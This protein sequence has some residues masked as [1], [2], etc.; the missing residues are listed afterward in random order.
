MNTDME[1]TLSK[2][3]WIEEIKRVAREKYE[4][5][6]VQLASYPWESLWELYGEEDQMTPAEAMEEELSRA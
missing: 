2:E 5:T 1:T 6:A 3:K 4:F